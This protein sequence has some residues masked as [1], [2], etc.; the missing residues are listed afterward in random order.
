MCVCV[1]AY[2]QESAES[3]RELEKSERVQQRGTKE[4]AESARELEKSKREQQ[5]GTKESAES[6]Q[7]QQRAMESSRE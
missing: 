5:R 2:A 3:D 4:S 6:K 1:H 7:E